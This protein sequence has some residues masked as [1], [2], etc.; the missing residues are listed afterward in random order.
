M[1]TDRQKDEQTDIQAG[2]TSD[3]LTKKLF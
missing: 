1:L 3:H 2:I